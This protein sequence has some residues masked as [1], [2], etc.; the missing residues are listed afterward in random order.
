MTTR[1]KYDYEDEDDYLSG[2]TY[3]AHEL[4]VYLQQSVNYLKRRYKG[5]FRFEIA[6]EKNTF[7]LSL[8]NNYLTSETTKYTRF[9]EDDFKVYNRTALQYMSNKETQTVSEIMEK[10]RTKMEKSLNRQGL[11][12]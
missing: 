10:L 9:H 5:S 12:K 7:K 2:H 6:P 3:S 11:K 4:I 8:V 1:K